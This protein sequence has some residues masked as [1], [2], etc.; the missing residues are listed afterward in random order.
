M[1]EKRGNKGDM[2]ISSI[3]I[4]KRGETANQAK[5]ITIPL[6]ECTNRIGL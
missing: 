3:D 2:V 5:P 4:R 1:G 6:M